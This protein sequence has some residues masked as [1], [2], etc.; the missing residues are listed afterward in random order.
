MFTKWSALLTWWFART[1]WGSQSPLDCIVS[2]VFLLSLINRTPVVGG[3]CVDL[4]HWLE[5]SFARVNKQELK[6]TTQN[7]L[8]FFFFI[9]RKN[10]YPK[11][12]VFKRK[13]RKSFGASSLEEN[14]DRGDFLFRIISWNVGLKLLGYVK[15]V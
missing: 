6:R 11:N 14:W 1:I 13:L 4:L 15:V 2:I 9:K 3:T 5:F 8:K 10:K 7:L 12:Q